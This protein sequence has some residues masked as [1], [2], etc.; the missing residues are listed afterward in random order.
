M[1][2][3][4]QLEHIKAPVSEDIDAV[5]KLI[6]EH[7]HSNLALI[8]ELAEH[9]VESGGKRLRPLLTL[10]TARAC[11]HTGDAHRLPAATIEFIHTAT[12]LH[13]DV[14]D[15][16]GLRR[17][18]ETARSIWG[19]S[20]SVLVGDF[21]YSRAFQMIVESGLPEATRVFAY[22]TNIIAEGEVRQLLNCGKTDTT[23]D[24]YL[25][26][27]RYKTAILFEAATRIGAIVAGAS[28]QTQRDSARFGLNSGI[29]FQLI[30]DALDYEVSKDTGKPP[31]KDI[32]EGKPTMPLIY[33]LE[34]CPPFERKLLEDTLRQ[35]S[36]THDDRLVW[37]AVELV[38]HSGAL[39]YTR[40]QAEAYADKAETA[41][42]GFPDSVYKTALEE[43]N[44][45]V[46][47][48][49]Y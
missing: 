20:A 49:D 47:S 44:R 15:D 43:L 13:D 48:R 8:H 38:H 45:F 2:S 42:S 6:G 29:A 22:A 37:K 21:L 7:L 5:D 4:S 46:L 14:V 36:D 18:H 24:D 10:L 19:N 9:I 12:L 3:P 39:D 23:E 27:I 30:D 1:P 26:I 16:A 17:G 25:Q 31:A 40:K 11:G 33:T 32:N 35:K 41:L 34:R 28:E